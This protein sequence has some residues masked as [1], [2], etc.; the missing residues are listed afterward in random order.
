[1][2][3]FVYW[4][5]ETIGRLGYPG[6][7]VLMFLESTFF[8]VPS[9]IVIPPAGYLA[10]RGEMNLVLVIMCG[11]AGSILGALFNYWLAVLLGRP[12]ILRYGKYFLLPPKRFERVNAFFTAH[13]EISTFTGR[14]VPGLRHFISF[15]AGLARMK[16]TTFLGYTALGS[17]VWVTILA[18]IGKVV[19]DNMDLVK[20]YSHQALLITLAVMAL[21][22]VVYVMQYRKR[23]LIKILDD[24]AR[25]TE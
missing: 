10:A 24:K 14:L 11:V 7:L 18:Y 4:L 20:K 1:M 6:V 15:P 5:V 8:P 21:V 12:L 17:A 19:G 16:M 22:F 9:E 3:D 2:E 23:S 13:G 25:R